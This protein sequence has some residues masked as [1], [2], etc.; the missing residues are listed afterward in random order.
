MAIIALFFAIFWGALSAQFVVQCILS[1]IVAAISL[2]GIAISKVPRSMNVAGTITGTGQLIIF[3]VLFVGGNWLSSKYIIDYGTWNANS[4]A[5]MLSFLTSTIYCIR[6]VA[7]K[8]LLTKMCSFTPGFMEAQMREPR[9][10][11][12]AFARKWRADAAAQTRLRA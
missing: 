2:V 3:G 8:I 5:A 1:F 11:R 7:G 4:I 6:Q 9:N 12:I 10:T